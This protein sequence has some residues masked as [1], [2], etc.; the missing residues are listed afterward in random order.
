PQTKPKVTAGFSWPPEMC[1]V[2]ET[3]AAM[4]NPWA[5]AMAR[6]SCPAVLIAPMPTKISANVPI[7]S[8]SNGRNLDIRRCNQITQ[9]LTIPDVDLTT[10]VIRIS[11]VQLPGQ[12]IRLSGLAS[13]LIRGRSFVQRARRDRGI[14]VKQSDTHESLAGIIEISALQLHVSRQQARLSIHTTFRL[15]GHNLFGDLL[16]V[17]WFVDADFNRAK[18]EQNF[19]FSCR[20]F[21][22]LQILAEGFLGL[23]QVFQ[24]RGCVPQI[25]QKV[26]LDAAAIV[27]LSQRTQIFFGSFV[28]FL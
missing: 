23:R 28:V 16:G 21:G 9:M 19:R 1:S 20:I 2:A 24:F 5:S 18:R 6:T 7:N 27:D 13:A 4:V 14:V 8:A 11:F 12:A 3:K 26:R 17:V 10:G 15:Q 25:K 22:D